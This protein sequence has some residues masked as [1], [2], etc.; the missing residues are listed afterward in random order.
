MNEYTTIAVWIAESISEKEIKDL[1]IIHNND[2]K[3]KIDFKIDD[4]SDLFDDEHQ[5]ILS[6]E[7][8]GYTGKK[9]DE[10]GNNELISDFWPQVEKKLRKMK[11][12]KINFVLAVPDFNY[13]G[14]IKSVDKIIFVD[15]FKYKETMDDVLEYFTKG[16]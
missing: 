2:I 14:K 12:D 5:I 9:I 7:E 8:L 6:I 11:I 10:I 3:L 4:N 1:F 16:L 15:N 13:K